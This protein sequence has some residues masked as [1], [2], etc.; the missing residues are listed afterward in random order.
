MIHNTYFQTHLEFKFIKFHM[1]VTDSRNSKLFNYNFPHFIFYI[2]TLSQK[3]IKRI[4]P[5]MIAFLLRNKNFFNSRPSYHIKEMSRCCPLLFGTKGSSIYFA[6]YIHYKHNTFSLIQWHLSH[7][8]N[9]K[10]YTKWIL[11]S[12][13]G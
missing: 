10:L 8:S 5:N 9:I 6:D 1:V 11:V 7:V 13:K 4:L 3:A 12:F 2:L